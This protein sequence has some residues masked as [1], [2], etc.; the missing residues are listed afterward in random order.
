MEHEKSCGTIIID[1]DKILLIGAKDDDGEMFWSFPKGHQENGETDVETALRET[2][3]EV[4]LIVKIIDRT[5]I[6]VS[7]AIHGGTVIK[8]IHLFLAKVKDGKIKPQVGEVE[9]CQWV[10]FNDVDDYLT[11]YYKEA[12]R[13]ARKHKV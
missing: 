13:K 10:N 6:I 9:Q 7:H 5:P 3:E 2:S 8:D 4:G 11:D 1:H 12:W